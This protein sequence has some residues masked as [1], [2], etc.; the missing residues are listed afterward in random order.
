[1]KLHRAKPEGSSVNASEPSRRPGSEEK[2]IVHSLAEGISAEELALVEEM[3]REVA[4]LQAK[5]SRKLERGIGITLVVLSIAGLIGSRAV[6]VRT[7]TGGIDPRWWPTVICAVT[8]V[9]SIMLIVV[10]LTKPP[11]DR[12]DLEVTNRDGWQRLMWTIILVV[13]FIM[14]WKLSGNFVVSSVALLVLVMWVNDGRGLKALVFYPLG[15][16]TCIYLVFHTLLRV[17]L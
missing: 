9:L 17:P 15:T 4:A 16:V 3:E 6:T 11:F 13:L 12:E 10:S 2:A 8:L 1:L 7:E 14:A 5:P